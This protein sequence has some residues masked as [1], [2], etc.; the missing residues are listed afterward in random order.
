[1]KMKLFTSVAFAALLIPGVA[2]AQS[3]GTIASEDSGDIVVKGTRGP[4]S[5]T[6]VA[7]GTTPKAS[8]ILNNEFLQ[9]SSPGQTVLE[10]LNQVPSV[11]FTNNDPTGASGGNIRIRGFDGNRISL[12]FDGLP[13]NDTGNYAIFSNQQLDP[14]IIDQVNVNQG[15]TDVDS[16]T[17]ASSGGTINYRTIVPSEKFGALARGS[18]GTSYAGR[19]ISRAFGMIQT[20]DIFN[21]GIRGFVSASVLQAEKYRGVGD[22]HKE[23]FNARLYK[24]FS[25]GDFISLAGHY[26]RNRNTSYRSLSLF[27]A[28]V[29]LNGVP[30]GTTG[31]TTTGTS[32]A[33]PLAGDGRFNFD[34]NPLCTRP[35]FVNG[36]A[37]SDNATA[38]SSTVIP[39]N[40]FVTRQDQ[41]T[42]QTVGGQDTSCTNYAG[43]RLNPS[44]TGNVRFNSKFTI[45]PNLTFTV[46]AGYQ[47]VLANGGGF[48][49]LSESSVQARAGGAVGRDFSG[50]G[51]TLDTVAFY[52]PN[53]TNTNRYT[54]LSSL[55]WDFADKQSIRIAY[56][57]DYG[58]HRQTGEW[59]P[60]DSIGNPANPFGGRGG[61]AQVND[62]NGYFLRQRDRFSIAELNQVSGEYRG[63][64]FDNILEV[65][66]GVRA[67]FFHRELN[68]YCYTFASSGNP[69]CTSQVLGTTLIPSAQA[70]TLGNY[71]IPNNT[72][73]TGGVPSNAVYAP[74]S[75]SYN[76]RKVLPNVGFTVNPGGGFQLYAAFA[77][78]LS[79]PRTDNLYRAPVVNVTP[80]TTNN[81]DV[82]IRYSSPMVQA[83]FGGFLN[84]F[85]NRIVTS[86]D[87]DQSSPTFGLSIDR[88]VG[89]VKIKGLEATLDVR[90]VKWFSVRGYGSYID[91]KYQDN[92]VI[93]SLVTLPLAGKKLVETPTWS[94]GLRSQVRFDPVSFGMNFKHV[95]SRTATDLNDVVLGAYDTVD[96]DARLSLGGLGMEKTYLQLNVNNLLDNQYLGS[97]SSQSSLPTNVAGLVTGTGITTA[98]GLGG[99]NP[100][101]QPASPRSWSIALQVAF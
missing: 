55:R 101:F 36:T 93:S 10:A 76:Y 84:N 62:I 41:L 35:T 52:A 74:F 95:S 13:L 49:T 31:L 80:E 46:D 6:G 3:S 96:L 18:Y 21:T 22:L 86:N 89:R 24:S 19:G 14:E 34:N 9:T 26:N 64:F 20:G 32:V 5:S 27:Q 23:Q 63:K 12:T 16:P 68:Q 43:V 53:T 65:M 37:Q 30:T 70:S 94:Y 59:T 72:V 45:T 61:A 42:T 28:Q 47:Y 91:A 77:Q 81:Y 67:P 51:D 71:L 58:R 40:F 4:R 38:Q 33:T 88:N 92:L 25:N 87:L 90:P 56:A 57:L 97:I 44:N 8:T 15:T 54:L 82:G 29:D 39:N 78:G 79:A 98:T 7:S 69:Y 60:L 83:T 100:T 99:S 48:T 73:F 1:M 75:K 66:L 85:K 2:F 50:D 17:A 11:N